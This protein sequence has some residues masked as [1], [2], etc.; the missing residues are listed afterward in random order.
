MHRPANSL[1]QRRQNPWPGFDQGDVHVFRLDP[2]QAIGRQ[3]VGRIVQFGGQFDSGGTG[4]D[5]GN[6]DLFD[7]VGLPGMRSQVMVEQLLVEALGLFA[8]VEEQAMLGRALGAEI[9]GRAAD[10]NHQRVVS[11]LPR[12]NQLQAGFVISGGQLD[13]LLRAIEPAHAPQLELEVVPFCLGNIIEFVFGRIQGTGRH[14]VQ[15]RFP[16]VGQIRVDQHYTGDAAFTQSLTQ[17]G[18]QLQTAGAAAND[19]NTMSHGDISQG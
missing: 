10:G 3:F 19:D 17:T 18:S 16:D 14:F 15:Q 8:G 1:W 5:D 4:A 11:H 12:R 13:F 7:L 9:V 2:I 6:A